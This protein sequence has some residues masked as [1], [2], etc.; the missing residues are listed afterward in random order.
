MHTCK[1]LIIHCMDFRLMEPIFSYLKKRGLVGMCDEVSLAGA[2]KSIA[3]DPNGPV[4][5]TLLK[6]I[7]LSKALHHIDTVILMNHTDCGAYGGHAAFASL[8]EER[9]KHTQDMRAVRNHITSRFP[10]LTVETVLADID[11]G[12]HFS[13]V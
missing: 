3:D 10:E 13:A 9:E 6:Q 8:T 1:A 2:I 11:I 5:Q 7:E 4:S 12:V